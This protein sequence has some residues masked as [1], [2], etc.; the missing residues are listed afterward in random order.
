MRGLRCRV[1]HADGCVE[2]VRV[3]DVG[4]DMIVSHRW[5]DLDGGLS[6]LCVSV[7]VMEV[8]EMVLFD[9]RDGVAC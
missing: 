6:G 7:A 2:G 5:S 8:C 9:A 1:S 4:S 3:P